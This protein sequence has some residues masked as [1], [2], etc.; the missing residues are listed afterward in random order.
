MNNI[1]IQDT[2]S[3]STGC[4]VADSS[5]NNFVI[6]GSTSKLST[7]L[8]GD[9]KHILDLIDELENE[10]N[11]KNEQSSL[12]IKTYKK[13]LESFIYEFHD[14]CKKIYDN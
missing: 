10:I 1:D 5:R 7:I 4:S 3:E 12:I 14:I 8:K 2:A 13:L 11:D 6:S 9:T